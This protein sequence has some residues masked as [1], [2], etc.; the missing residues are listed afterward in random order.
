MR[1]LTEEQRQWLIDNYPI[2]LTRECAEHLGLTLLQTQQSAQ[3]MGLKKTQFIKSLSSSINSRMGHDKAMASGRKEWRFQ[4]G[5]K[6]IDRFGKEVEERRAKS[7][8]AG[9]LNVFR[10]ERRR[11][12]FGLPQ[13][14]RLK[15]C[16]GGRRRSTQRS[17]LRRMGYDVPYGSNIAYILPTTKRN[18]DYESKTTG[19]EYK[20]L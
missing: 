13:K 19:I 20:I 1:L 5:V 17:R 3:R 8:S 18:L 4:R 16:T 9:M 12:L 11:I 7:M 14:T 15:L 2:K 6:N 10:A